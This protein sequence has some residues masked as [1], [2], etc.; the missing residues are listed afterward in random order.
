MKKKILYNIAIIF[1]LFV[2]CN[3]TKNNSAINSSIKLLPCEIGYNDAKMVASTN[4]NLLICLFLIVVRRKHPT[5]PSKS[6]SKHQSCF[7]VME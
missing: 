4:G 7:C 5:E 1:L 3:K 6:E 2:S